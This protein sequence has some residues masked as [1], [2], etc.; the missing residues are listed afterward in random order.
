LCHRL[1]LQYKAET[2]SSSGAVLTTWTTDSTVWGAIEP[3]SGSEYLSASQTQNETDVRI[4]MRYHATIDKTWRIR[5]TDER[6]SPGTKV[7]YSI[8]SIIDH[9]NRHQWLTVM[10]SQ[11]V[12]EEVA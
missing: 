1:T 12:A 6:S 8:K 5:W 9:D 3:L 11:G 10:C 4:F 2:R 7:Y